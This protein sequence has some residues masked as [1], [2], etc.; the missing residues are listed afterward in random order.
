MPSGLTGT[1]LVL[2]DDT[3]VVL[4]IQTQATGEDQHDLVLDLVALERQPLAGLDDQHLPGVSIGVGPD[5]F[6]A[7]RLVERARSCAAHQSLT[8]V[9][10]RVACLGGRR[11]G[12][13]A[14]ERLGAGCP[15]QQP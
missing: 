9:D 15:D 1:Q 5:Q 3:L 2:A 12:V 11:L 10:H 7:P 13:D 6:V 14:N 4:E 8:R